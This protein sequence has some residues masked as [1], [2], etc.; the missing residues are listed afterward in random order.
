ML[1]Y[2]KDWQLPLPSSKRRSESAGIVRAEGK[3]K[4]KL[5]LKVW[6]IES[7]KE[8]MHQNLINQE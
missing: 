4:P 7:W 8:L 1:S 6:R 5:A 2:P 3:L